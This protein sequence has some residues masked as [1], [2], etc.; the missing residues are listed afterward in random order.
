[1]ITIKPYQYEEIKTYAKKI[2][3]KI[4][5]M[6]RNYSSF[7]ARELDLGHDDKFA[8]LILF[9]ISE[10]IYSAHLELKEK[11]RVKDK[12]KIES[13]EDLEKLIDDFSSIIEQ[14]KKR[15]RNNE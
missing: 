6:V 11:N 12:S 1:M 10:E 3:E 14:Y 7:M 8:E 13:N 5:F 9:D 15:R 4:E 2:H